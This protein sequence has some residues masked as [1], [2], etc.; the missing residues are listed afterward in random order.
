MLAGEILQE[1]RGIQD[2]VSTSTKRTQ[3]SEQAEHD[4]VGSSAGD[5]GEDRGDEQRNIEGEAT[6][7][8]VGR[9]APEQRANQHSHIDGNG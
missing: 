6:A 3:T 9:E 4:P 8:D 5:N 7:D 1:D 2:Q